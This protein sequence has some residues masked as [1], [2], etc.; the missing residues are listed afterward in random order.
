MKKKWIVFLALMFVLSPFIVATA[1]DL[2]D[3]MDSAGQ[4]IGK[5]LEPV[6]EDVNYLGRSMFYGIGAI[7]IAPFRFVQDAINAI[8]QG[9]SN[10]KLWDHTNLLH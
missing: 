10:E 2:E 7:V 9:T 4:E 3:G 1:G 8:A 5:G 6:G